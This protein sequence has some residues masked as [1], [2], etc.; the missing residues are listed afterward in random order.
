VE[1]TAVVTVK[2]LAVG[3]CEEAISATEDEVI[4]VMLRPAVV[5]VLKA[6]GVVGTG[7]TSAV[8]WLSYTSG[9]WLLAT[10]D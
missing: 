9:A 7:A 6:M 4:G 5:V 10:T 2:V 8:P 1:Y 3:T